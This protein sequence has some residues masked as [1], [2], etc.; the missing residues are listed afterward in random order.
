MF[1]DQDIARQKSIRVDYMT[2]LLRRSDRIVH[3]AFHHATHHVAPKSM[4]TSF[5]SDPALR[6]I[7]STSSSDSGSNTCPPRMLRKGGSCRETPKI[8]GAVVSDCFD[9][10]APAMVAPALVA[11]TAGMTAKRTAIKL[12]NRREN[13]VIVNIPVVSYYAKCDPSH[14]LDRTSWKTACR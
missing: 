1:A 4:T 7:A 6:R 14:R 3:R 9:G 11:P 2:R 5:C 8:E 10:Q 13:I 12:Q